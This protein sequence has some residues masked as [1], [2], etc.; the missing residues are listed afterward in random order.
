[1]CKMCVGC[2]NAHLC[3]CLTGDVFLLLLANL[4]IDSRGAGGVLLPGQEPKDPDEAEDIK[5][6]GPLQVGHH[7]GRQGQPHDGA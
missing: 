3:D 6:G 7:V 1:M 4:V 5:D 2:R